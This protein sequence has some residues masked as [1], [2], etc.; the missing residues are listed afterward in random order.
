[1]YYVDGGHACAWAVALV[2]V[3]RRDGSSGALACSGQGALISEGGPD[4]GEGLLIGM[5][6]P[7][8][9]S[10]CLI[11]LFPAKPSEPLC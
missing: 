6:Y 7:Y 10:C 4:P 9:A 3:T 8:P 1:M 5:K 11:L 2:D